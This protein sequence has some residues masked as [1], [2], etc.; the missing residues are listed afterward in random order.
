MLHVIIDTSIYRSD[1]KR[2]KGAFRAFTRL[3]EGRKVTLYIPEYVKG[4]FVSQQKATVVDEI[5]KIIAA[6]KSITRRS[7]DERLVTFSEEVSKAAEKILPKAGVLTTE[8]FIRWAKRC[9]AVAAKIRPEHAAR[10]M[11]DYFEGAPPFSSPKHRNDIPDS[12]IWQ[13]VCDLA[14]NMFTSSQMT[15]DSS[16]RR[17]L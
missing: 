15:E 12:F 7:R 6:A 14:N 16:K 3:C 2:G 4:E 10:V 5:Q 11:E 1:P 17:K 13:T 8:E 9:N